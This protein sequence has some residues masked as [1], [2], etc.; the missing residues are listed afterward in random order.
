MRRA[1][2]AVACSRSSSG[3]VKE[4]KD[5]LRGEMGKSSGGGE[6]VFWF[7]GERGMGNAT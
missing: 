7:M 1:A 3:G 4:S 2:A 6:C 5:W